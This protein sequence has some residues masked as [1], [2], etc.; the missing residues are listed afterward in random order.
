[1]H[2]FY[3]RQNYFLNKLIAKKKKYIRRRK[4]NEKMVRNV[5][6]L[7]L[8]KRHQLIDLN[9]DKVNFE[10]KFNIVA[11]NEQIF[12]VII[13]TQAE[14]DNYDNLSD[15]DMRVAPGKIS[16]TISS[17]ENKYDNYVLILRSDAENPVKVD[18]VIDLEEVEADVQ[19]KI[20]EDIPDYENTTTSSNAK[21]DVN[22]PIWKT[23][24]FW[25]VIVFG[26]LFFSYFAFNYISIRKMN[27]SKD[28]KLS[29]VANAVPDEPVPVENAA[30]YE[31]PKK[32]SIYNT[33]KDIANAA[34]E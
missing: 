11:E 30:M 17:K 4:I 27:A 33:L 12:H 21:N 8:T 34:N 26:I 5:Q 10:L 31:D 14:V 24:W 32:T 28:H 29:A 25:V 22:K 7:E 20:M 23:T 6:T 9:K 3:E 1:L 13:M 18:I 16:G 15:I 2:G 19:E